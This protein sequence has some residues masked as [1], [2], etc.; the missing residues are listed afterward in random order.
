[1][2]YMSGLDDTS[3]PAPTARAIA[4]ELLEMIMGQAKKVEVAGRRVNIKPRRPAGYTYAYLDRLVG[5]GLTGREWDAG[6]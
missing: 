4:S 1:M 6:K 5:T 3:V 2:Y